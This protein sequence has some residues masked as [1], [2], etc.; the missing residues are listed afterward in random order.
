MHPEP[1]ISHNEFEVGQRPRLLHELALRQSLLPYFDLEKL[2][3]DSWPDDLEWFFT[4]ADKEML[5]LEYSQSSSMEIHVIQFGPP[6]QVFDVYTAS[7]FSVSLEHAL[8]FLSQQCTTYGFW[9][10]AIEVRE[11]DGLTIDL[12]VNGGML[13]RVIRLRSTPLKSEVLRTRAMGIW[14]GLRKADRPVHEF[15]SRIRRWPGLS[16]FTPVLYQDT[17]R[18]VGHLPE[19]GEWLLSAKLLFSQ[20]GVNTP[21]ANEVQDVASKVLG[22]KSWN[23]VS[24]AYKSRAGKTLPLTGSVWSVVEVDDEDPWAIDHSSYF[25][26][27]YDGLIHW[28]NRAVEFVRKYPNFSFRMAADVVSEIR[29]IPSIRLTARPAKPLPDDPFLASLEESHLPYLE[30]AYCSD[31]AAEPDWLDRTL[32]LTK[33]DLRAGLFALFQVDSTVHQRYELRNEIWRRRFL[34]TSGPWKFSVSDLDVH[35]QSTGYLYVDLLD[36]RGNI[37][38]SASVGLWKGQLTWDEETQCH[39]LTGEYGLK[40][41]VA[42][43]RNLNGE[44]VAVIRSVLRDGRER[45]IGPLVRSDGEY[46]HLK[47]H[48]TPH[49]SIDKYPRG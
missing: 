24:A 22:F 20:A 19:P 13:A 36:K 45:P 29:G 42:L 7:M 6:A 26:D 47:K 44:E 30:L 18:A 23:H 28:L 9:P 17:D 8:G 21:K 10:D 3:P 34:F 43:I 31:V 37:A 41:P 5:D 39:V 33:D 35:R 11:T 46:I 49:G 15:V 16:D 48:I 38:S 40:K 25:V 1:E 2:F 14:K 27:A 4:K 12:L 32:I